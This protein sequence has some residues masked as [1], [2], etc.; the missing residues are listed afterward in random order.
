MRL[1]ASDV[2][3]SGGGATI[4]NLSGAKVSGVKRA[5]IA[6]WRNTAPKQLVQE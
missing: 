6:A 4:I 2:R 5:L 3:F 1:A